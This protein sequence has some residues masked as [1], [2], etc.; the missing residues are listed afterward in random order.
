[1]EFLDAYDQ[2]T[3]YFVGRFHPPGGSWLDPVAIGLTHL[4][5]W[6]VLTAV[7]LLA[8]LV[9][10]RA[11]RRVLALALVLG[12][13]AGWGLEW[14]VKAQV[15]RIRPDVLWRVIEL[16]DNSSF[17][18]GHAL[19]SMCIYSLV[20]LLLAGLLPGSRFRWVLPLLGIGLGLLIGGTRVWL[21]VHYPL[22]VLAGW[23]AGLGIALLTADLAFRA[24]GKS[25]TAGQRSPSDP[26]L[27]PDGSI[28]IISS[29]AVQP[30]QRTS[31]P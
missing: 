12:A 2:G 27:P 24:E 22:D 6:G 9:L 26:P 21:G 31:Q 4:G 19:N 8:V 1:M 13:L 3:L 28:Q 15:R 23:L 7:V 10:L 18:S 5:D 30:S 14:S 29:H 11:R 17:P 20:G 16:P 25:N